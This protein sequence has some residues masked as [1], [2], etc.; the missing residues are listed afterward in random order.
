MKKTLALLLAVAFTMVSMAGCSSSNNQ[1]ASSTAAVQST[2]AAQSTDTASKGYRIGFTCND[3]TN[4]TFADV[5]TSLKKLGEKDNIQVTALDCTSN[6]SKQITQVENFIQTGVDA[7]IIQSADATA[8]KSALKTAKDKGIK[9]ISWDDDLGDSDD[10]AWVLKNY[11]LGVIIGTA[12]AKWNNEKLGGKG[13]VA[14]LDYPSLPICVERTKGITDTIAKLTPNAKIVAEASTLNAAQG[15]ANTETI[16]RAHPNVKVI[17]CDGDGDAIGAVQAAK[18][19]GKNTPDFGTFSADGTD[20]AL[21]GM[22]AGDPIRMTVSYGSGDMQASQL[23]DIVTKLLKGE[24]VDKVV[25]KTLTPV[26]MDN[27]KDF[28]KK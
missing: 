23:L 10:V 2:D 22:V 9:V 14:L 18:A 3:L 19:A 20:Q 24:K 13:E 28:Y 26:T 7:I 1:T 5:A 15:M 27:V 25:Y 17:V 21:A 8:L 6:A 16:L 12:A 4:P 11:D